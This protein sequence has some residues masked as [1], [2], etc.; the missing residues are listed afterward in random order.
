MTAKE[1]RTKLA[2]LYA[3]GEYKEASQLAN[4]YWFFI[5]RGKSRSLTIN[6]VSQYL[7]GAPHDPYKRKAMIAHVQ[8]HGEKNWRE[9]AEMFGYASADS[10]RASYLELIGRK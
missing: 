5:P 3:M 8:K 1:F 6:D 9:V 7:N 10:A 4:K 2:T